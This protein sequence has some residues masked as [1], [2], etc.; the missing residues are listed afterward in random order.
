VSVRRVVTG[1]DEK[2][3]SFFVSDE[4]VE[5]LRFEPGGW[6]FDMLWGGES[7]PSVPNDGA[8]PEWSTYYPGPGGFRFSFSTIVPDDSLEPSGELPEK[9][10]WMDVRGLLDALDPDDVGMH[11]NPSFDME[12]VL[13]GEV[14]LELD[15]GDER[16]LTV[17]DTVIQNGT[18]H[19]WRNPGPA[20]VVLAVFILGPGVGPDGR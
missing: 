5:P 8:Q 14:I 9:I 12:V 2:G 16:H 18:R 1:N 7:S 19:R 17:G 6:S 4:Q 13:A 20:N 11:T 10:G 3:K 15:D